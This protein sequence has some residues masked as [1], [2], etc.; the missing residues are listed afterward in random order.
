MTGTFIPPGNKGQRNALQLP[1]H[2]R[3][4]EKLH[5]LSEYSALKEAKLQTPKLD[6]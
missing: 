3:C 4:Q 1:G 6:W 5:F 2:G